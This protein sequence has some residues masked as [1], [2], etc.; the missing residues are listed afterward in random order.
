[1]SSSAPNNLHSAVSTIFLLF[2][3]L[4]V[5]M[6]FKARPTK[7]FDFGWQF[8]F[9]QLFPFSLSFF[10]IRTTCLAFKIIFSTFLHFNHHPG[11]RSHSKQATSF[12]MPSP[13]IILYTQT[14]WNLE[15]RFTVH[16]IEKVSHY[17]CFP[18]HRSMVN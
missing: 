15:D 16:M 3:T 13:T 7:D 6:E 5:G 12:I 14:Y 2:S 4:P 1:M 11:S 10:Y 18:C 8:H 17:F 9:P